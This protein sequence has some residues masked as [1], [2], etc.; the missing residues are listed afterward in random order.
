MYIRLCMPLTISREVRGE[1]GAHLDSG[2]VHAR[3]LNGH[4]RIRHCRRLG[5]PYRLRREHRPEGGTCRQ[6]TGECTRV[7]TLPSIVD[8][9]W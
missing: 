3:L 2:G 9:W 7:A 6:H 8:R 1:A 4:V 5:V